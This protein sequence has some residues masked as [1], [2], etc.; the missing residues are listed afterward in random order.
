MSEDPLARSLSGKSVLLESIIGLHLDAGKLCFVPCL[1]AKWESLEVAYRYG[2]T[3]YN[4]QMRN[5]AGRGGDMQV[6]LDG[7]VQAGQSIALTDDG[8]RHQVVV[9]LSEIN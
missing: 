4:I 7:I 5:V 2:E 6:T 8:V 3:V 9:E 1:P